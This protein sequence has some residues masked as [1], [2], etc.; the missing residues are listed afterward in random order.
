MSVYCSHCYEVCK[1][2]YYL[3]GDNEICQKCIGEYVVTIS[4]DDE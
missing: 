1:D 3:F 2:H 4:G